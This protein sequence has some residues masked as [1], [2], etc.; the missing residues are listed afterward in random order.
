MELTINGKT[1]ILPEEATTL[2]RFLEAKG[3]NPLMLVVEYN[4]E[5]LARDT[6]DAVQLQ[7]GDVLEIVQMMAGG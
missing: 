5:I 6:Y 2:S 1:V 7:P 4:G 3:L